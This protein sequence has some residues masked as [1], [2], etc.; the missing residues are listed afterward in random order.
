ML[1][2]LSRQEY[3]AS[4]LKTKLLSKEFPVEEVDAAIAFAQEHKF[5][6][7][8]RYA[9]SKARTTS[10]R[11]GNWRL[12][13]GLMQKGI[14]EE[15]ASAQLEHL[16]P[17]EERVIGVVKKFEGKELTPEQRQKIYRFLASRGFSSKPIKAALSHLER[18]WKESEAESTEE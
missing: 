14:S 4:A 9:Q 8:E 13:Q 7:D 2:L 10:S 1:W 6:S 5:Q 12:K 18:I 3:T 15:L 17:E 16:E 11:H